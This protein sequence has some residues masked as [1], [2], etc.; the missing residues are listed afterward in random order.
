MVTR[1]YAAGEDASK[2]ER[3]KALLL[4]AFGP[5][6]IKLFY[7]LDA[8]NASPTPA[9]GNAFKNAVAHFH[10]H[11][12][13]VSCD[14]LARVK[15]QERRQLPGEPV[16]E[17]IT[18]LRTLAASCGFGAFEADMIRHQLF[19]GVA[20]QDA[21]CRM[22]K[23][24]SSI[25]L[26]EALS[27]ARADELIRSQLEQFALHPVQQLSAAG[28]QGGGPS[29]S[30]WRGGQ[31]GRPPA[32]SFRGGRHGGLSAS[33]GQSSGLIGLGSSTRWHLNR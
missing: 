10:E 28:G 33:R 5:A 1:T 7:T 20:S 3:R 32:Q 11:F 31:H 22:L 19:T 21:R 8:T 29:S 17:F 13:D 26:S 9:S 30:S 15:F 16:A 2:A 14:Y 25:S 27:I 24:G 18:S 4:N 12:K 23:K 6:G